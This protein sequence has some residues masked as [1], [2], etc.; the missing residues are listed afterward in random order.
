MTSRSVQAGRNAIIGSL[1]V[2]AILMLVNYVSAGLFARLDLTENK[3]YTVSQ[4]TKDVLGRMDDLVTVRAYFSRD[5]PSYLATLNRDVRDLLNEFRAFSGGNLLVEFQ[6]PSTDPELENKVRRL[7]IPQVQLDVIE[8]DSR[9]LRNAWLGMAVSF[10]DR[11]EIIPVVSSVETLEY[12]LTAAILKVRQTED[13]VLGFLTGHL[14]PDLFTEL[15]STRQILERQYIVR[16]VDLD[17]GR[18]GIPEDINTLIIAGSTGINDREKYLIDQFIMNGGKLVL[19]EDAIHLMSGQLSA[20]QVRSGLENLMPH[21]GLKVSEDLVLDALAEQAGFSS[22]FMR[23]MVR[24]PYW[25]KI[26]SISK[27]FN[28]EHPIVAR[29]EALTLP[30][31]SPIEESELKPETVEF[32]PLA[33]TSERSWTISGPFDLNPQQQFAPPGEMRPHVVAAAL[34]G[35][36]T[37]YFAD[38]EIPEAPAD[39]TEA[40][41]PETED[42]T[43]DEDKLAESLAETQIVVVGTSH[44]IRENFLQQFPTN[45]TFLQNV[46]DWM[47]LGD[48]L[49]DIRSRTV[50]D[51]PLK[52]E[53]LADEAEGTRNAIKFLGI[54]GMPI[55]L[56]IVGVARWMA[57]RREKRAFEEGLHH[58]GETD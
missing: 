3:E 9:E 18:R 33:S 19:L 50:S 6:D 40:L 52:P 7:G 46:I 27:G 58:V 31:V 44:F 34:T 28:T 1:I 57:R 55:V 36:F 12:D 30:W 56:G 39:T 51:R 48:E 25:P 49:I 4:S 20:R 21:Y 10:E 17:Q 41:T 37:S 8:A 15:E 43:A 35:T 13:K 26:S 5:L 11:T 14:E 42:E 45:L 53:V 24:Y 29:L 54:F 32:I 22:G 38:R 16:Q 23:F 47:T 2:L